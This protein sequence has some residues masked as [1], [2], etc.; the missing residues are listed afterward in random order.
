MQ[1]NFYKIFGN[2]SIMTHVLCR[3]TA[4]QKTLL[5]CSNLLCMRHKFLV[6]I[7]LCNSW[8]THLASVHIFPIL[9]EPT[10][11]TLCTTLHKTLE[12]YYYC[13]TFKMWI[14]MQLVNALPAFMF[15]LFTQTPFLESFFF[16]QFTFAHSVLLNLI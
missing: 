8:P 9:R 11:D 14:I 12:D 6:Q 13:N 1:D 3:S 7:K 16:S 10:E 4:Q 5:T 2:I 15:I